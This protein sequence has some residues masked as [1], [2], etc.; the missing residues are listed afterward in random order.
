MAQASTHTFQ[1][2]ALAPSARHPGWEAIRTFLGSA[3]AA[4]Q[5]SA[6]SIFDFDPRTSTFKQTTSLPLSGTE[7][8][9]AHQPD[10]QAALRRDTLIVFSLRASPNMGEAFPEYAL[11]EEGTFDIEK[12]DL[13]FGAQVAKLEVALER[14]ARALMAFH[15]GEPL[16]LIQ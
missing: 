3:F 2:W 12:C 5:I 15:D 6:V 13:L 7:T 11:S 14:G 9:T 16:F 4:T 10:I 1:E 8:L